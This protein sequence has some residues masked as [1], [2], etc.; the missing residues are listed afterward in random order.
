MHTHHPTQK[1]TAART[2]YISVSC[3]NGH[4][5]ASCHLVARFSLQEPM[6]ICVIFLMDKAVTEHISLAGLHF[7]TVSIIPPILHTPL[8]I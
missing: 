1:L 8:F 2:L 6:A 3:L 7:S 4:A 5:A